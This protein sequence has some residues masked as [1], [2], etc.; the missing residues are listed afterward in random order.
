MLTLPG[1]AGR[2]AQA[3]VSLAKG[4]ALMTSARTLLPVDDPYQ[5]RVIVG[6][7]AEAFN[8]CAGRSVDVPPTENP[9]WPV[10]CRMVEAMSRDHYR[11]AAFAIDG[12]FGP[13]RGSGRPVSMLRHRG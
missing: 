13:A 12:S 6:Y 3:H 2:D 10:A 5:A 1:G 9:L 7:L 8:P 11:L 4:S